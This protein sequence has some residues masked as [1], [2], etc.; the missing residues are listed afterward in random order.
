MSAAKTS[1]LRCSHRLSLLSHALVWLRFASDTVAQPVRT[2]PVMKEGKAALQK[3]SDDLGL[4]FDDAD[5]DY[6]AKV[7]VEQAR[8]AACCSRLWGA[9]EAF[10]S[11]ATRSRTADTLPL[12]IL[13]PFPPPA[14]A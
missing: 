2:V 6:Y 8:P 12:P 9:A 7:F 3:V 4:G 10:S 1:G 13:A 11:D 14:P 5:I